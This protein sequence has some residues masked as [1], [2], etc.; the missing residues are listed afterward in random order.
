L[1]VW[2]AEDGYDAIQ[3]AK[4]LNPDLIILDL[5][6]PRMNGIEAARVL[7]KILPQTPIVMLSSHDPSTL[8]YDTRA[9][10]V[11]MRLL[12][13]TPICPY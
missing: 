1:S 12:Q 10:G 11:L 4:E 6:M 13:R 3:K 5:S 2:Q 8:G 7:K 9:A